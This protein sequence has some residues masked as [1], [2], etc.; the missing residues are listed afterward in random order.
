MTGLHGHG[1][2]ATSPHCA[3]G[4]TGR[5][6]VDAGLS[7]APRAPPA[8][9]LGYWERHS[10]DDLAVTA[11]RNELLKSADQNPE[12]YAAFL[13]LLRSGRRDAVCAAPEP[14]VAAVLG[15]V[16]VI[17]PQPDGQR[18]AGSPCRSRG[19]PSAAR[20]TAAP[21]DARPGHRPPNSASPFRDTAGMVMWK[22]AALS[23]S[24]SSGADAR[25]WEPPVVGGAAAR[26]RA[27]CTTAARSGWTSRNPTRKPTRPVTSTTCR[28]SPTT[29]RH[30]SASTAQ[31][32][33]GEVAGPPPQHQDH[34]GHPRPAR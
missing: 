11:E 21:A 22:T 34:H 27:A 25:W 5:S 32:E 17:K 7:T 6:S 8:M 14:V 12:P 15:G 1:E 26:N 31:E 18:A 23:K 10:L 9:T 28:R 24:A 2:G 3:L 13:N 4:C 19:P 20:C 16:E 29:S 33:D 30:R